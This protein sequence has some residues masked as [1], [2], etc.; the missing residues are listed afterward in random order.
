MAA[1]AMSKYGPM[2]LKHRVMWWLEDLPEWADVI[3]SPI[4]WLNCRVLGHSPVQDQ[5][6]CSDHDYCSCC[7]KGMPN[8]APR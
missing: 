4:R 3:D 1:V 6:A 7:M 8:K 5:C 2:P